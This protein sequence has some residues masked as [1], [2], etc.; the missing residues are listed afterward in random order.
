MAAVWLLVTLPAVAENVVVVA[1]AA[2]LAE[3]GTVNAEALLDSETSTP[4]AGAAVDSVTVQVDAR[5]LAKLEGLH[6]SELTRVG[7]SEMAAVSVPPL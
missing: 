5:P 3:T 6:A 4:P 7:P 2:M 1:P